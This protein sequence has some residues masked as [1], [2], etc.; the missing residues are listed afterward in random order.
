MAPAGHDGPPPPHLDPGPGELD[1]VTLLAVGTAPPGIT[2]AGNVPDQPL[3]Y[4]NEAFTDMTGYA[5]TEVLGRNCRFLQGA[6][7]NPAYVAR[8]SRAIHDGRDISVVLR[9][10]RS[11][12]A[13]FWK[14]G[15]HLPDP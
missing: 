4:A 5:V 6:G 7:T 11:D 3:V 13:L 9:N 10:Y 8:L 15:V 14:R 12:G 2:I 1:Q